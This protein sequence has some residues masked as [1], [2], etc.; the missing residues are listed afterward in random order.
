MVAFANCHKYQLQKL[1]WEICCYLNFRLST[2][3]FDIHVLK[4]TIQHLRDI[5][6]REN[7]TPIVYHL[8]PNT[9]M[10]FIINELILQLKYHYPHLQRKEAREY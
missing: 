3:V 10:N 5:V 8:V 7:T 4:I 6:D 2:S 9:G 1:P